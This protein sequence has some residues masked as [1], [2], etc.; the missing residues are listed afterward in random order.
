MSA[1][2]LLLPLYNVRKQTRRLSEKNLIV[3]LLGTTLVSLYLILR[4]LPSN[5]NI[6]ENE[7]INAVFVPRIDKNAQRAANERVI[8][9]EHDRH[10]FKPIERKRIDEMKQPG[11]GEKQKDEVVVPE[12]PKPKPPVEEKPPVKVE[13]DPKKEENLAR[14]AKVKEVKPRVFGIFN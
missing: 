2:Q 4:N 14:R 3:I 5:V 12:K 10:D 1:K 8:H 13:H 9:N 11:A 7:G 6:V